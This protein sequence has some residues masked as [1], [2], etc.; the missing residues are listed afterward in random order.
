[1]KLHVNRGHASAQQVRGV[2]V[3]SDGGNLQLLTSVNEVSEQREVRKA[4]D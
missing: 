3:H 4:F 2:L 1:M